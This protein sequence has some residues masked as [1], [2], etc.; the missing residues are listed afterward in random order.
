VLVANGAFAAAI[1]GAAERIAARGSSIAS[2][3]SLE[4]VGESVGDKVGYEP[5]LADGGFAAEQIK[6]RFLATGL[7]A[8]WQPHRQWRLDAQFRTQTLTAKRDQF[9]VQGFDFGVDYVF[10][11]ELHAWQFSLASSVSRNSSNNFEKNS[12]TNYNN[13]TFKQTNVNGASDWRAETNLVANRALGSSGWMLSA[14]AGAGR[15]KSDFSEL[16]G[17]VSQDGCEYRFQTD[18]NGGSTELVQPCDSL[19]N[20]RQQYPNAETFEAKYG[21]NANADIRQNSHYWQTGAQILLQQERFELGLGYHFRQYRR[22]AM[23]ARL[24]QRGLAFSTVNHTVGTWLTYR[25]TPRFAINAG[26]EYSQHPLMNRLSL[27][28]TGFTSHRFGTPAVTFSISARV[29]IGK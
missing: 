13:T 1:D 21:F 24:R 14:H 18:G 3:W 17:R 10:A 28:Y 20:L 27:L 4:L 2:D 9:T 5:N 26:A 7:T 22:G 16:S 29:L 11:R 25:V 8:R 23:D 12:Y 19:V 6:P 15:L